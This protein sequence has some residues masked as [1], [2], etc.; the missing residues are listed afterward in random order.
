M[1]DKRAFY[2]NAPDLCIR[3]YASLCIDSHEPL[4]LSEEAE[5]FNNAT[6]DNWKNQ[7]KIFRSWVEKRSKK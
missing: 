6:S 3:S 5:A 7:Q 1:Q 2:A 4:L